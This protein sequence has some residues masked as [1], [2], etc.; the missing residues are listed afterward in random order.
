MGLLDALL[1]DPYRMNVWIAVRA[2]GV[3]GTGTQNDPYDG[4][5]QPKFDAVMNSLP[6]TPPVAVHLGPGLFS[7]NGYTDAA[8]GQGWQPKPGMKILGSGIDVT[9]LQL[10]G[11]STNNAHFYAVGHAVTSS[12]QTE[13][14]GF[15]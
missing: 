11:G 7:T 4:S 8:P 2:D 1:L 10:A 3:P 5:T 9:T 15:F 14:N 12:G 6:S 13:P